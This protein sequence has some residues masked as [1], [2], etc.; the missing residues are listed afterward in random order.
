MPKSVALLSLRS[1][2]G[3][4][5]YDNSFFNSDMD[6]KFENMVAGFIR[7]GGLF[8]PGERVLLAVSGGADSVAL[9]YVISRLKD[10]G[11]LDVEIAIG[12]VN[13]NLRGSEAEADERFVVDLAKGLEVPVY[14]RSVDTRGYADANKVSIE[15][16]GRML[17]MEALGKMAGEWGCA[18]IVT[19]H[20]RDDNAETMVHRMRRGTGFRGLGG[21]WPRRQFDSGMVYVRPMLC[22]G[23]GEIVE[24]CRVNGLVWRHDKTNDEFGYTRNR[25]RHLLMPMLQAESSCDIAEELLKLSVNARRLGCKIS[26][27]T[28]AAWEKIL[29]SEDE[30][31]V[32]FQKAKF[33]GLPALIKSELAL[34]GLVM[35]GCGQRDLTELQ[36]GRIS[37]LVNEDGSKSIDLPNGYKAGIWRGELVFSAPAEKAEKQEGPVELEIGGKAEFAGWII[38]TDILDASEHNLETFKTN[39]DSQVEWFDMDKVVGSITLR[40][41][42]EGD[43]FVPI[44]FDSGKKIGKFITAAKVSPDL[45]RDV[46]VVE[47][48]EKIIWLAP[49]RASARTCVIRTTK[50]ILQIKIR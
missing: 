3:L 47:D 21:I 46:F 26:D 19:A 17:R 43:K 10:A 44:G 9:A 5:W 32:R 48:T 1:R 16:A 30:N 50:R 11:R 36:Y 33:A 15:T 38:K 24:Y 45:R 18:T 20:H 22:A 6:N 31:Q 8:A 29:I 35:L 13:H 28:E 49:L 23:R 12:H 14:T 39:K 34:K 27:V 37:Q 4:L 7:E 2:F 40:R 41:R 25:I 42:R